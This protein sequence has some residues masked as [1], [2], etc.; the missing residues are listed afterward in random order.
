VGYAPILPLLNDR[1]RQMETLAAAA[2]EAGAQWL[3]GGVLF[4]SESTRPVFF[5]F[6]ER[7]FPHLLAKYKPRFERSAYLKGDYPER[8]NARLGAVRARYGL[9]GRGEGEGSSWVRDG[10]LSEEDVQMSLRF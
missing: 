8:I 3:W 9:H 5:A 4:L 7:E 2:H 10:N 1:N 6:L